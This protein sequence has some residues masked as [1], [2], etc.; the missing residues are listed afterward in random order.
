M[1]CTGTYQVWNEIDDQQ[2]SLSFEITLQSRVEACGNK[3]CLKA[4]MII[5]DTINDVATVEA[6]K[7]ESHVQVLPKSLDINVAHGFCD[8][9]EKN[10]YELHSTNWELSLQEI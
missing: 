1:H 6:K 7:D 5:G 9:W 4:K 3:Y 2:I 10:Y 8:L